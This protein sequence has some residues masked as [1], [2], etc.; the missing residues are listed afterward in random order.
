MRYR[1]L[2]ITFSAVC[3]AV[4][5]LLIVLWLR[6]YWYFDQYAGPGWSGT[7]GCTSAQGVL[8]FSTSTDIVV[9]GMWTRRS[10]Y[11]STNLALFPAS[12]PLSYKP[13]KPALLPWIEFN[14]NHLIEPGSS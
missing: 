9:G 14:R 12:V 7:C 3:G 5:V 11:N 1:K 6:S 2:R 4:C 10:W 13:A 8:L